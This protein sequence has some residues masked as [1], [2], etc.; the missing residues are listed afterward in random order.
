VI[1]EQRALDISN[2]ISEGIR[3][4]TYLEVVEVVKYW[5]NQYDQLWN[6]RQSENDQSG[7][8][9]MSL[10]IEIMHGQVLH[11][12]KM[13]QKKPPTRT[14]LKQLKARLKKSQSA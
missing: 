8:A 5:R 14:L 11:G 2:D 1:S 13:L 3:N 12:L 9:L 7:S 4:A 10:G 6:L